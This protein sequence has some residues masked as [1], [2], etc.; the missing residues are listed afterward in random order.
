M[1]PVIKPEAAKQALAYDGAK[2]ALCSAT[3]DNE[4]RAPAGTRQAHLQL[5]TNL[6]S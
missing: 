2:Q 6:A 3:S 1:R 5:D 4:G